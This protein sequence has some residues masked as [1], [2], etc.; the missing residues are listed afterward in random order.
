MA[1]VRFTF[2]QSPEVV[3][4]F[5]TDPERVKAR[6]VSF[7]EREVKV[8]K[9]GDTI[10]N[11]RLVEGEV[12]AFAKKL[13]TPVNTVIDVKTWD[14]ASKSARFEV[15]VKGV[16]VKISGTIAITANGAGADYVV[17]YRV[18]CKIPLIGGKLEEYV[19]G[20]TEKGLRNELEWNQKTLD[21]A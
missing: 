18:S 7:G 11:T 15:D 10:T 6:S 16:P 2:K 5:V 19:S 4:G 8:E 20:S 13:F 12:P 21:Q 1:T 14:P 3:Y 9:N 17:D